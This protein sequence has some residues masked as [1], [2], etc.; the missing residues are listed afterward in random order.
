MIFFGDHQNAKG[1]DSP[2]H[3]DV[4]EPFLSC[5]LDHSDQPVHLQCFVLISASQNDEAV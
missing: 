1:V 4:I 3:E 2:V 5:L